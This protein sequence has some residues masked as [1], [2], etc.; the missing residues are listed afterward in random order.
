MQKIVKMSG[1]A[2]KLNDVDA[3]DDN[4]ALEDEISDAES[5][6]QQQDVQK[7]VKQKDRDET[8]GKAVKSEKKAKHSFKWSDV[9]P[10]LAVCV[11]VL[12]LSSVCVI[13]STVND[14]FISVSSGEEAQ[15]GNVVLVD[16]VGSF[17]GYYDEKDADG[18]YIGVVFDTSISSVGNNGSFI[19]SSEFSKATYA[20]IKVTIGK[21]AYLAMF[22]DALIGHVAGDVIR[23]EIPAVNGYGEVK[24]SDKKTVGMSSGSVSVMQNMPEDKFFKLFGFHPSG[25]MNEVTSPYGWNCNI[26]LNSDSTVTI[27]NQPEVGK[28]YKMQGNENVTHEV[29]SNADGVIKFNYAFTK[30]TPDKVDKGNVELIKILV[31]GTET[32]YVYN[33]NDTAKEFSYKTCQEKIGMSLFFTITFKEFAK[34]N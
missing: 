17:Y 3:K 22:E 12:I 13:A 19:K 32:A 29:T 5:E 7:S 21:G 31:N 2:K 18:N 23:V 20:P 28:T 14:K 27:V 26:F 8:A 24:E 1:K 9:D 25:N 4:F 34:A 10:I 33:V 30:T 6:I 11:V 15:Y 16:Y